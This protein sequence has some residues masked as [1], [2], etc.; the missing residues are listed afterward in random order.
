M[1]LAYLY[2]PKVSSNPVISNPHYQ[3]TQ[4]LWVDN[5]RTQN[6]IPNGSF[7]K[8]YF[9]IQ[10]AVNQVSGSIETTNG[11]V[12]HVAPGVYAENLVIDRPVTIRGSNSKDTI[13]SSTLVNPTVI[14][15]S[16]V[17]LENLYVSV[18]GGEELENVILKNVEATTVGFYSCFNILLDGCTF[19]DDALFVNC[20]LLIRNH[21]QHSGQFNFWSSDQY[22]FPEDLPSNTSVLRAH[23]VAFIEDGAVGVLMVA[24]ACYMTADICNSVFT[25]DVNVPA[26]A[27]LNNCCSTF[28]AGLG[29]IVGTYNNYGGYPEEAI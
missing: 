4:E 22:P 14:T 11:M 15:A 24:E 28:K 6:Y 27:T 20:G 23:S 10:A 7:E 25:G 3:T 17:V 16:Y 8:P 9:T 29:T 1:T 21:E 18:T 19:Y 26:G 2:S 13:I 5:K 12:V